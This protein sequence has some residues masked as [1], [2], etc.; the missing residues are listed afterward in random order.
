VTRVEELLAPEAM[1]AIEAAVRGAERETSGEIVPVVVERS[2]SYADVRIGAAAI[3]TLALG[4]VALAFLPGHSPWFV[5]AQLCAFAALCWGFGWRPLL[6]LV[7]PNP[8]FADRVHRA[9]SLAFHEAGL[10][11][12]RDRTGILIYVSLLEHRVEVLADRG[13]H[14]RVREGAWDAVVERV[15]AG[16]REQRADEGLIE[17]I[18]LCGEIL[19]GNVPPRADDRDE[20]PNRPRGA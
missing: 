17:G 20:L 19:A 10:V 6:G 13:I 12:T 5:P 16:I 2:D 4:G 1:A 11:E 7:A 15:V 3:L 18:R 8:L 9:A 14:Q